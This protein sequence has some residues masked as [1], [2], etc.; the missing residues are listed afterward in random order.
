MHR[1]TLPPPVPMSVHEEIE[2]WK[3]IQNVYM[4]AKKNYGMQRPVLIA[5]RELTKPDFWT[6]LQCEK[7][8]G[9]FDSGISTLENVLTSLPNCPYIEFK[10][11]YELLAL[12]PR[13]TGMTYEEFD[14]LE[15]A[16]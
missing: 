7:E 11:R 9:Y 10:I 3:Y 5:L 13:F 14:A 16:G 12:F 1:K 8:T 15:Q 2:K 4:R 6:Q